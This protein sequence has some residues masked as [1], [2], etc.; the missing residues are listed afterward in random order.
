MYDVFL[1]RRA[2][3]DLKRL[4]VEIFHRVIPEIQSL[5]TNPRPRGCRK[6]VGASDY[7]IRVGDYRVLYEIGLMTL[8]WKYVSC[9]CVT[10]RKFTGD[11]RQRV[12]YHYDVCRLRELQEATGRRVTSVEKSAPRFAMSPVATAKARGC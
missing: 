3:R 4:S 11:I 8:Q 2:E 5:G 6:L 12:R 9:V 7:R 1:A 10:E